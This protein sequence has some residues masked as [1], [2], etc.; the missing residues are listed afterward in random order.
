MLLLNTPCCAG[1]VVVLTRRVCRGEPPL[2]MLALDLLH[3]LRQQ[4]HALTGG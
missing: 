3:V 1:G 2:R 4:G